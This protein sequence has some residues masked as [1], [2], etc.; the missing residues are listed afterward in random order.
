MSVR[1]GGSDEILA[2]QIKKLT[3]EYR[4]KFDLRGTL[5]IHNI[6][7]TLE[8]CSASAR[9]GGGWGLQVKGSTSTFVPAP[10]YVNVLDPLRQIKN[11]ASSTSSSGIP[12]TD[13]T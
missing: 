10:R 6:S 11:R 12:K 7:K 9:R 1:R 13:Y 2:V 8:P 3:V 4:Q 5:A